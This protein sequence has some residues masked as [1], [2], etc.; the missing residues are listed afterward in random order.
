MEPLFVALLELRRWKNQGQTSPT[1][2]IFLLHLTG[3]TGATQ[4]HRKSCGWALILAQKTLFQDPKALN[5]RW[6]GHWGVIHGSIPAIPTLCFQL[7]LTAPLST[8]PLFKGNVTA[9]KGSTSKRRLV[10]YFKFTHMTEIILCLPAKT[11]RLEPHQ[12]KEQQEKNGSLCYTKLNFVVSGGK[13]FFDDQ[14]W[15]NK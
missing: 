4:F 10:F 12:A 5:M 6:R 2:Q 15:S 9:M 11:S 14:S 7:A 8:F 13:A 1:K 3:K